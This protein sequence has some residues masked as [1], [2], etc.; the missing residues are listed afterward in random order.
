MANLFSDLQ[1]S[2]ATRLRADSAFSTPPR[3]AVLTEDLGSVYQEIAQRIGE[4][5]IVVSI[6]TPG[7]KPDEMHPDFFV[8]TVEV[9]VAENTLTNRGPT[10]TQR[11]AGDIAIAVTAILN[12]FKPAGGWRELVFKGA[13]VRGITNDIVTYAVTFETAIHAVAEAA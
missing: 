6:I 7:W 3:I 10:G 9:G 4:C 13:N 8:A 2:M 1:E 12:R 5:G 11:K